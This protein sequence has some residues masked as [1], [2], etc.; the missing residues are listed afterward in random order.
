[1]AIA[2]VMKCASD[3]LVELKAIHPKRGI[4]RSII[5]II[6]DQIAKIK[7]FQ[8]TPNSAHRYRPT[9][10]NTDNE[11]GTLQHIHTA[12]RRIDGQTDT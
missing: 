6:L 7:I 10:S 5:W 12:D 8:K 2:H 3:I 1:V 9:S 4:I 11:F